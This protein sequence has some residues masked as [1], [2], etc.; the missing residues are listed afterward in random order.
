MLEAV[1]ENN[2]QQVIIHI[3]NGADVNCEDPFS[4]YK[5]T[6]LITAARLGYTDM[7]KLLV[8][9]GALIDK[10][11]VTG[12]TALCEASWFNRIDTVKLLLDLGAEPDIQNNEGNT[13]LAEAARLGHYDLVKLL[14]ENNASPE[15]LNFEGSLPAELTK[16]SEI[17]KL[18]IK[19]MKLTK[20]VLFW[21]RN[22]IRI[23]IF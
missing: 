18:L 1:R 7:I 14:L 17:K 16:N 23:K 9:H 20:K 2:L 5:H 19:K 3:N 11:S 13:A 15:I 8:S 22:L 4:P 21:I 12:F 10:K 6:P